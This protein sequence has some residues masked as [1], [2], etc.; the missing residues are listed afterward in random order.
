MKKYNF[1]LIFLFRCNKGYEFPSGV[2]TYEQCGQDS[3]Y[4]WSFEVA[5]D[6]NGLDPAGTH[7]IT[8]CIRE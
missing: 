2:N 4:R 1:F 3:D 8:D 7:R 6:P 5:Q